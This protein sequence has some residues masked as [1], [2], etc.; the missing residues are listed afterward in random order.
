MDNYKTFV[1]DSINEHDKNMKEQRKLLKDAMFFDY[2]EVNSDIENDKIVFYDENDKKILKA[3]FE[4][5]STYNIMYNIWTWGWGDPS[6]RR[7]WTRI[8]TKIANYGFT[9]DPQKNYHLKLELINSRFSIS[10][11]LQIDIHLSITS[12]L[13]KIPNIYGIV[14]PLDDDPEKSQF[15]FSEEKKR[16]KILKNFKGSYKI[17]YLFLFNIETSTR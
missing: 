12:A 14:L 10:D 7:K 6:F 9:L 1:T 13:S 4:I 11:Q 5:V 16:F 15:L 17:L 2:I 3:D 8:I